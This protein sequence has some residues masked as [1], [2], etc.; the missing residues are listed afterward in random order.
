MSE[1]CRKHGYNYYRKP[2][3][4]C[5]IEALEQAGD[6]LA[7]F[8]ECIGYESSEW[9]STCRKAEMA[10]DNWRKVRGE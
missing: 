9:A 8:V 4:V 10:L 5:K 3:L 1:F 6:E 2:C 7:R